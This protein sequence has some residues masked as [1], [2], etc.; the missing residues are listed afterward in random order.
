MG[1][2]DYD[3]EFDAEIGVWRVDDKDKKKWYPYNQKGIPAKII[4]ADPKDN[5]LEPPYPGMP[6]KKKKK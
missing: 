6:P 1:K 4:N 2:K 3:S 5:G